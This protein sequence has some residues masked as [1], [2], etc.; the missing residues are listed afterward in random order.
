MAATS[1]NTNLLD[2]HASLLGIYM[3]ACSKRYKK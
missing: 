1:K 3:Y 2:I